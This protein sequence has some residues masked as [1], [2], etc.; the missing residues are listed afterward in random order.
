MIIAI[1]VFREKL[2]A[3]YY[4]QANQAKETMLI[5]NDE[6]VNFSREIENTKKNQV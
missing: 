5:M 6:R 2:Q 3:G 1:E 4:N